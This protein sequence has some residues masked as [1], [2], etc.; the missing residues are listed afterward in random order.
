MEIC[1][2][3]PK[4]EIAEN[5]TEELIKQINQHIISDIESKYY[6]EK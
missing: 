4:A 6:I 3:D 5:L 2:R 1:R